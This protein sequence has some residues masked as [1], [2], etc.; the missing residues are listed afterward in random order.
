MRVSSPTG[1][2][3]PSDLRPSGRVPP[4]ESFTEAFVRQSEADALV[5][6]SERNVGIRQV[7]DRRRYD[8]SL[9]LA[10]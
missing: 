7:V 3:S 1:S 8:E 9:C 5:Q 10:T 6:M 2:A 4:F